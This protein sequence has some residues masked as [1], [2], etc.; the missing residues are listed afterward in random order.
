MR[1]A[2][3]AA[4]LV[5]HLPWAHAHLGS[6]EV[7]VRNGFYQPQELRIDAGETVTWHAFAA[8]HSITAD[9][10]RFDFPSSGLTQQGDRFEWTFTEDETVWFHCRVHRSSMFGIIVVG[11]GSSPTPPT[12]DPPEVRAVPGGYPTI[13][14]ALTDAPAGS[15]IE[16]APGPYRESVV[17][18]V[19]GIVL[20]GTGASPADV[21]IE[22]GAVRGIGVSILAADVR[23]E[24]LTVRRATF[25]GIAVG[26]VARATIDSVVVEDNGQYGIRMAGARGGVVREVRARDS[27]RAGIAIEAC[28]ACDVVID[29]VT[30]ERN[31]AGIAATDATGVVIRYSTIRGN[32]TGIALRSTA[33]P[34]T[35]PQRGA[36]VYGNLIRGNVLRPSTRPREAGPLEIPTGSGIWIAGG[37]QNLIEH[38]DLAGHLY[39]VAVTGLGGPSIDATIRLNTVGDAT[40]ADLA[41]D[42]IGAGVCFEHNT[43]P[44][45]EPPLIERLSPCSAVPA[46][47]VPYPLVTAMILLFATG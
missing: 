27:R 38:N 8:G 40:R 44:S 22:G 35:A 30:V 23:V 34:Q 42:G 9:D 21:R 2:L 19:P 7:Q 17:V 1:L 16:L 12:S 31:L 13:G 4:V 11:E 32:G 29:R 14:A 24:N 28:D 3:L 46:P 10:G 26:A 39:N 47:G 25:A 5:A 36:H 6:H 33:G 41:W 18:D 20:R 15:V 43:G 37:R 45:S